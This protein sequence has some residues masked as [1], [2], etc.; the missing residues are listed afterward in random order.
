MKSDM[1]FGVLAFLHWN[2]DWNEWHFSPPEL[3]GG[4]DLL[5]ALGVGFVRMDILWSDVNRGDSGFDFSRYDG[6]IESLTGRGIGLLAA[7]QYNKKHDEGGI[8]VWNHPPNN[9]DEFAAYV[10]ATVS[11]FKDHVHHWEIWNE[12]NHP[13]YWQPPRDDLKTYARLLRLSYAAAKQADPGCVVLNGGLTEPLVEDVRHLYE[14]RGNETMDILSVHTF[15]DPLAPDRSE[16][17]DGIIR[18]IRQVMEDHGELHKKIWI[19]EMGCPGIPA[20]RPSHPWFAGEGVSESQQ[21]DWLEE[22]YGYINR[23][24]FI[25]KMFWAFFRDTEGMF[26]DA[27]D[28]LGLVRTDLS[29][30]PAYERMKR[31]IEN[32]E[33]KKTA[34]AR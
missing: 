11:H 30:K 4:I 14:Q 1:P 31:L 16:K 29:P 12:P 15:L 8:E 27:T 19:T 3:A 34:E 26:K 13:V 2:H 7:L 20:N 22:Q 18:G 21:A 28:Y 32:W 23:Y 24:P 5:D 33:R 25:E 17:F 9:F 6:I 10:H